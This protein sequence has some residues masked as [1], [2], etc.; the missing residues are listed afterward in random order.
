MGKQKRFG[1]NN[2]KIVCDE[3][4]TNNR[5]KG[6]CGSHSYVCRNTAK[7]QCIKICVIL[8]GKEYPDVV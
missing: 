2:Q 6:M 8:K 3:T 4:D 7:N 5:W 1:R